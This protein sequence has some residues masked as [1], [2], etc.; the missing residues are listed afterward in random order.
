MIAIKHCKPWDAHCDSGILVIRVSMKEGEIILAWVLLFSA[1]IFYVIFL[2]VYLSQSRYKDG[3]LLG[4]LLPAHAADIEP[5]RQIRE[6]YRKQLL[7]ISTVMALILVLPLLLLQKWM[8]FQTVYFLLWM[9]T[10]ILVVTV[11]FRRS[12]RELLALKRRQEWYVNLGPDGPEDG[13]EYWGNGFTYHNPKDPRVFVDKRI[14]TGMTLNTGTA[15]GKMIMGGTAVLI[16]G[17]IVG[18]SFMLI[19]S[20]LTSPVMNITEEQVEIHYPM[21]NYAFAIDEIEALALVEEIPSGLR[22][23]GEATDRYARGIFRLRELGKAR[24]YIFKA[25]P[26]YLQIKLPDLY[27]YY[28]DENPQQTERW[29]NILQQKFLENQRDSS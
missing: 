10:F 12:F 3:Q 28:N 7:V 20:E 29:Y 25:H 2:A 8:A 5:V 18:V 15:A 21:Y 19:R 16:L 22:L 17:I 24:L 23:N 27:I 14:G 13:D 6:R 9:S 11:P 4:I 1:V 26:P